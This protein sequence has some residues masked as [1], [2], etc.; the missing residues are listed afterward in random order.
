MEKAPFIFLQDEPERDKR[1]AKLWGMG[2][3]SGYYT[4]EE[5]EQKTGVSPNEFPNL[6][7]QTESGLCCWTEKADKI[8]KTRSNASKL[9]RETLGIR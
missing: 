7:K 9:C 3:S 8:C 2:L 1:L 5:W 4:A 6:I